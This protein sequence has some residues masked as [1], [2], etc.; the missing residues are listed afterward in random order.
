M[1]Q[2]IWLIPWDFSLFLI[3]SFALLAILFIRGLRI[4]SSVTCSRRIFFWSG[5]ILLYLS[6]QSR[7]DYYAERVFFIHRIQHLIIHHAGP[8]FLMISYPGSVIRSGIS[9]KIR[10]YLRKLS[11]SNFG[12]IITKLLSHRILVPF[13]FVFLV[14]VWLIPIVQFYSMIDWRL[15]RLMNWSVLISGIMYWNLILDP[16]VSPPSS[17]KPGS[18]VIS[19]VF[20]MLPQMI[21]GAVITFSEHDLYPL[22]ELCGRAIPLEPQADQ[23]LG[24]LIIWIISSCFEFVGIL[25]ALK[26]FMRLSAIG[27]LD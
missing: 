27:R 6:M 12:S 9:L 23:V 4:R 15:Y 17:M 26:A 20:S 2:L 13:L 3:C 22:F 11:N 18:R 19:P 5:I 16:R 10:H 14:L 24:G 21:A 7:L 1:N 8:F 25:V